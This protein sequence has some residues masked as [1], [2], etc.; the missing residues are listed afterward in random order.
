[1]RRRHTILVVDDEPDVVK[2]VQD[3]LRLDYKVLGAT[4][5][6][7]A[8][9]ILNREIVDVV[10]TDQRM[11]EMSGVEFL[12]K[13]R[14]QHPD[15][16]RLLFTGY[17][18]IRAVIDAINEGNVY[19]YITKP[20]D[21]E[22]LQTVIREACERRDL[23][24][25]RQK[26]LEELKTKNEALEKSDALKQAFIE[27]ASHELRTP[28]TILSGLVGLSLRVQSLGEPLKDWLKRIDQAGQRLQTLVNQLVNM[29]EAKKFDR[30]VEK[31]TVDLAGL[32]KQSVDDVRPFIELR[33][34]ALELD[35]AADLDSMEL[36][37]LKIRDCINHLLLNAIKF[38]PDS[39]KIGLAAS[40]GSDGSA[41]I[42][43]TDTGIGIDSSCQKQLF[44]PFFTG[45]DVSHHSSGHYEYGRKGIGLGLSVVKAF[46]EMHGGTI[47]VRS[48]VGKGT[49][50]TIALPA[51]APATSDAT[52]SAP[53]R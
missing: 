40:R 34:Q 2:S 52:A 47:G 32:L 10:M 30:P 14:E 4:R 41:S 43:V 33:K 26:L 39:G 37:E 53:R 21:P 44:E 11:P 19:R 38:T 9:V 35:I 28:L 13:A 20:W 18:D 31:K 12:R 51:A 6:N 3:L 46:V 29:L 49:I 23:L 15:A 22:E 42:S 7:D 24:A 5:A 8:L 27:V 48:E 17:A 50:F 25:E 45:F 16:I 36:D 1:M